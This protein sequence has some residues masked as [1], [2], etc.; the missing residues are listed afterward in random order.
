MPDYLAIPQVECHCGQDIA[1]IGVGAFFNEG[2][3]VRSDNLV[4]DPVRHLSAA[5][6]SPEGINRSL[7]RQA[8]R[9]ARGTITI[10]NDHL[11][12]IRI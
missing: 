8:H 9:R 5:H 12:V 1:S 11:R 2:D 6:V 3:A 4:S 10:D 7:A